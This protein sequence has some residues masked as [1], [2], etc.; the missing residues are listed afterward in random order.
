MSNY[1]DSNAF[2]VDT[3][4][5]RD[6]VS[7]LLDE[8]KIALQ[9]YEHIDRMKKL[10]DPTLYQKYDSVLSNI[11]QLVCYFQKMAESL[12]HI[13][14]DAVNLSCVI[15]EIINDETEKVKVITSES[16]ML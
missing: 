1:V 11:E 15:G 3:R 6:Q 7:E 13:E 14:Q 8:K 2:F 4:Y 12:E 10:D 9:L 5:L 16:F